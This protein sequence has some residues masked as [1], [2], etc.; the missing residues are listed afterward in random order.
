[1]L[2]GHRANERD[3]SIGWKK[4]RD[5]CLRAPLWE[6]CLAFV[7]GRSSTSSPTQ[8][9]PHAETSSEKS[10]YSTTS[11]S[12]E[13]TSDTTSKTTPPEEPDG[14]G[15]PWADMTANCPLRKT[16]TS[17]RWADGC[18]DECLLSHPQR[19]KGRGS[20]AGNTYCSA[21]WIAW[22]RNCEENCPACATWPEVQM[23]N[24]RCCHNTK[25][26]KQTI[27]KLY[28]KE[29]ARQAIHVVMAN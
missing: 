5:A 26:K 23:L 1:M 16:P 4:Y 13:S 24:L 6:Q 22:K 29:K 28:R 11:T 21:C 8:R 19:Y 10:T 18:C 2:L 25:E 12:G 17:F 9:T 27:C 7:A 20:W 3:G 14:A 15:N